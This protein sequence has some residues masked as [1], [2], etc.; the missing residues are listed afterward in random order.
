V[1]LLVV[2]LGLVAGCGGPDYGGAQ[3]H[4]HD[5]L[6]LRG[7]PRTVLVASHIGLYRT[8]DGG[9]SWTEVAGGGGQPMDG[10]MIYKLAQSPTDPR[11][12]YV[13][14]I[15]R[16]DDKAAAKDKP[17][18]YMSGD[19]GKTWKL[20]TDAATLPSPSIFTIATG[21]ASSGQLYTLI[22]AL[23]DHGLYTTQ[24]AG[25]H[26]QSLANLPGSN[27]T[28][29]VGDPAHAQHL[30]LYSPSSGLFASGD[31]GQSWSA[32]QGISGGVISAAFAGSSTVYAIGDLGVYVS[33][34]DGASFTL[35]TRDFTFSSVI[36]SPDDANHAYA[37]TGT[38][39]YAT[40]DGGQSWKQAAA[41]SQHP[42]NLTVDPANVATAYVGFSYPI[43]VMA[44]SDSGAHW[45]AVLP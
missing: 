29:L 20:A 43:G 27:V 1:L 21:A 13:L 44:T 14:A 40:S 35:T 19:A 32:A 18:V 31:G 9:K 37:T 5:L 41:T 22:P 11:R 28:G 2:A 39:V 3:N 45:Q 23:G 24:D 12:V 33:H 15:P 10:L 17:G 34:D 16:P 38:S 42:T 26:W 4:I 6:A 36:A 8:E 30:L 7:V 25:A